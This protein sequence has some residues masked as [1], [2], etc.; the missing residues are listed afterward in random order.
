MVTL[1]FASVGML[2][3]P[4]W[5]LTH[6]HWIVAAALAIF[7]AKSLLIFGI[8]RLFGLDRRHALATGITLAQVGE[9]SL[10][11]A[12]AGRGGG[13]LGA[14]GFDLIVS[15]IIALMFAAPYMVSQAFLLT[16]RLLTVMMG[17]HSASRLQSQAEKMESPNRVLV[18]GLGPAGQEVVRHLKH[19]QLELVVI[20]TN[21]QSRIKAHE[22]GVK[23]HLGDAASEDILLHA[24]FQNICMAVVTVPDPVSALR[25][26][27]TMRRLKSELPIAVRCRYNRY[28]DDIKQAGADIIIDEE[29]HLGHDLAH[30]IVDFM[31]KGTGIGLACRLAGRIDSRASQQNGP[32]G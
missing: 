31:Q 7:I 26:V 23:I 27:E 5:I 18:V 24:E 15:V 13:I 3:K 25:I 16:D 10:V 11:L 29:T 17:R 14:D 22:M 32:S 9:F 8:G 21:P 28:L 6:I 2:A 30:Q 1:F 4:A 12:V 20:D 19:A